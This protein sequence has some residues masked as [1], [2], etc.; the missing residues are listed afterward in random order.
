VTEWRH[1]VIY[2]W[3]NH[4][5]TQTIIQNGWKASLTVNDASLCQHH[6]QLNFLLIKQNGLWLVK[7]M[8]WLVCELAH[9]RLVQWPRYLQAWLQVFICLEVWAKCGDMGVQVWQWA[10]CMPAQ[11]CTNAEGLKPWSNSMLL[12]HLR[13]TFKINTTKFQRPH[14]S[15]YNVT[16]IYAVQTIF[17]SSSCFIRWPIYC[18][19][20]SSWGLKT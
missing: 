9:K 16:A 2:S 7:S 6:L 18:L 1:F 14:F 5:T 15:V 20:L 8:S 17:Y 10:N 3:N 12:L 13:A 11:W 19:S 4:G